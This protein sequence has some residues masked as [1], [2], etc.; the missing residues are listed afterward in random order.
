MVLRFLSI[1]PH[2]PPNKFDISK[3]NIK[4]GDVLGRQTDLIKRQWIMVP[5]LSPLFG[6]PFP[7]KGETQL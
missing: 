4:V 5:F 6:F 7:H 3:F 2:K 1:W